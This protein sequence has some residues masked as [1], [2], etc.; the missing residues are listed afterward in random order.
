MEEMA[1][2]AAVAAAEAAEEAAWDDAEE[3]APQAESVSARQSA[4]A[5]ARRTECFKGKPPVLREICF[6]CPK[7]RVKTIIRRKRQK[8][9]RI[10]RRRG[11]FHENIVEC[12][13]LLETG[14]PDRYNGAE[15]GAAVRRAVPETGKRSVQA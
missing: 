6:G 1:L 8:G 9:N 12:R 3:A 2:G 14:R 13:R 7:A 10:F 15:K 11:D 4:A 5:P